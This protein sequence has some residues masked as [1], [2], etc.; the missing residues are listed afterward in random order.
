MIQSEAVSKL[1]KAARVITY[2]HLEDAFTTGLVAERAKV[3]RIKNER[4]EVRRLMTNFETCDDLDFTVAHRYADAEIMHST[5]KNYL[6][7]LQQLHCP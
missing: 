4:N 2:V 3:R 6:Q 7:A 5:W 1:I